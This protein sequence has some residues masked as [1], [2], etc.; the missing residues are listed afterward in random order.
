LAFQS[1]AYRMQ[2]TVR[3]HSDVNEKLYNTVYSTQSASVALSY[4][5]HNVRLALLNIITTVACSVLV[6]PTGADTGL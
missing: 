6:V 2:C 5:M 3:C 1:G 4:A